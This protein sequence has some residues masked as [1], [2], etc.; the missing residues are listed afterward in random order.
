MDWHD[1]LGWAVAVS[2]V[3]FVGSLIVIP[4]LIVRIPADYFA[5]RE[6]A[7]ARLQR[8]RHPA[9]RVA[10]L[11]LK[12]VAGVLLLAAGVVMLATPGQGILSILVGLMLVDFPGK[13]GLERRIVGN[14]RVLKT[15]NAIRTRAGRAPLERPT[16][17]LVRHGGA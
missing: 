10:L 15:L 4:L 16:A 17:N 13:H 1:A 3:A 8:S 11:V 6:S 12:N 9:V 5:R 7:A 2:A 14:P